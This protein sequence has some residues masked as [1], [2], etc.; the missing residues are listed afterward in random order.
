MTSRPPTPDPWLDALLQAEREAPGPDAETQARLWLRLEESVALVESA[1]SP[2]AAAEAVTPRL[3]S[4]GSAEIANVG[5]LFG[6]MIG[7][8]ALGAL[9]VGA[10]AHGPRP[11]LPEAPTPALVSADDNTQRG[12][13][14]PE[15]ATTATPAKTR[16]TVAMAVGHEPL[17]AAEKETALGV[18]VGDAEASNVAPGETASPETSPKAARADPTVNAGARP[19]VDVKPAH[20]KLEKRGKGDRKKRAT[21]RRLRREKADAQPKAAPSPGGGTPASDLRAELRLVRA[22]RKAIADGR[23][24]QALTS[25]RTHASRFPSGQLREEREALQVVAFARQGKRSKASEAARAFLRR[26]PSS[27]QTGIVRA[28]T[29]PQP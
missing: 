17:R 5:T 15:S 2:A 22:A 20:A 9:L 13:V 11:S 3:L 26:Y 18:G 16:A 23:P 14:V 21:K 19:K 24:T 28:A 10:A 27:M 1:P 12:E 7:P 6:W 8:M 29:Q 4:Q 25:L